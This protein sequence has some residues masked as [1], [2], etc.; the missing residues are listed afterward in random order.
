M[1]LVSRRDV[2][3]IGGGHN[4]LVT[5]GLLARGGLDVVVVEQRE[6]TGGISELLPTAGRLRRSVIDALKLRSHGLELIRPEI[7]ML[8]LRDEGDPIAFWSDAERTAAA[9]EQVD[10]VDAGAYVAYDRHVRALSGF[11]ARMNRTTPA[12]LDKATPRDVVEGLK[13]GKAYRGLG[14]RTARELTRALPMAAA[15][16]VR[17]WFR[18]DAIC[19]ALAARGTLM[20]ELGPWSAGSALVLLND[21]AE[22]DGGAAG[23]TAL[24]R[25][26]PQALGDALAA[27]ARAA[28]AEVRT[29]TAVEQLI[30]EDG[31]ITGVT[32]AGGERID[33]LAV[34]SS[35][36]P[37]TTLCTLLDPVAAGPRTR[38][39]GAN[40]RTCG[41]AAVVELELSG[42]PAFRGADDPAML[43]GRI[44]VSRGIDDVERAF[45]AS[46]YGETSERPQIEAVLEDETRLR[47][48][49]QWVARTA[50]EDAVAD[51]AI[52]ELERFAPGLRELVTGRRVL[53]PAGL[54]AEY[55]MSGGH[56]LHAEPGLDQFFAWR[57]V[58]GM[59]RYRLGMRGLYLCG[60]GAHPGGGITGGPGENAAREIARDLER[61]R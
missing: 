52:G 36:D 43:A 33:A 50:A 26:G 32:L 49:V 60:S 47:A 16:F 38:W 3:V 40:I 34:A 1:A 57:P 11:L 48:I 51:L 6:R 25:G 44:V 39:R 58:L 12:R 37:K 10:P 53:T 31:R 5:A 28:G 55:G 2:I 29:G 22:G 54:E 9:L 21:I 19:G 42:T 20:T 30:V 15:D 61:G 23:E 27:A 13:L 35:L 14:A 7:R 4:G 17:E 18:D 24:V 56:L 45:D 41:H 8:A 59:A 46:K